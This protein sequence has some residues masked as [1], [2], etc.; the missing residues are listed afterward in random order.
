MAP[1][2]RDVALSILLLLSIFWLGFLVH[3]SPRFAGGPWGGFFGVTAAVMLLIAGSYSLF[4]RIEPLRRR[5]ATNVSIGTLLTAHIY[6]GLLGALLGLIHTG[7]KFDSTLGVALTTLML[8][9]VVSGFIGQYFLRYVSDD[10]R[11]KERQ[12]AEMWRILDAQMRSLAAGPLGAAISKEAAARFL[13]AATVAAELQYA[14]RFQERLRRMFAVWV[15]I[16]IAC[17]ILFYSLLGLHVWAALRF[18]L[19]W[20]Q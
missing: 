18:G 17:S 7:H 8:L 2:D 6:L 16:H 1:K 12:L 13:P 4:R 9:V 11:V 15:R 20:F 10:I 5:I 14:I 19:R 3:R